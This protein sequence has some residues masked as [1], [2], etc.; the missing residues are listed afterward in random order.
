VTSLNTYASVV[1]FST[2]DKYLIKSLRENKKYG[3]K[4][5]LKM[6]PNKNWSLGGLKALIKKLTTQVLCGQCRDDYYPI[7][8]TTVPVLSIFLIS[9]FSPPRLQFFL[10]NIFLIFSQTFDEILIFS[11]KSYH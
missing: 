5:L 11:A 1:G 2:E 10:G 4:Q 7:R 6:F 8:R 3:A 9:A